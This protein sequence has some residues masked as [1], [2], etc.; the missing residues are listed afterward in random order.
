M[1]SEHSHHHPR[2]VFEAVPIQRIKGG[3]TFLYV[4]GGALRNLP[5]EAFQDE[6]LSKSWE[7]EAWKAVHKLMR[8]RKVGDR[9]ASTIALSLRG[10]FDLSRG[11]SD[12][13]VNFSLTSFASRLWNVLL[14][15][16]ES[17]NSLLQVKDV[18]E[19]VDLVR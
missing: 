18:P 4:D 2:F 3:P 19:S 15:G 1:C 10:A 5:L 8:I 11:M 9:S 6:T 13:T 7:D 16:P 17:S 14:W 12:A